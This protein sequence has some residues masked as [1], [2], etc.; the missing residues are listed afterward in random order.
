[1]RILKCIRI[2]L[3]IFFLAVDLSPLIAGYVCGHYRNGSGVKKARTTARRRRSVLNGQ[4][5]RN[6]SKGMKAKKLQQQGG[7]C[8][9]CGKFG[10]MK[11]MEADHIIPY[12]KGGRT[13]WSNLQILCR[14]CNRSNGNRYSH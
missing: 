12:S 11:D 10:S 7:R 8:A 2:L 3:L 14:T 5:P 13:S 9:H 6:F 4:S 1:M